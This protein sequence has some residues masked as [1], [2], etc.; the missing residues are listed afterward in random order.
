MRLNVYLLLYM[1]SAASSV[2]RVIAQSGYNMGHKRQL[3]LPRPRRP[4]YIKDDSHHRDDEHCDVHYLCKQLWA[5]EWA[6]HNL[7]YLMMTKSAMILC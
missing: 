1:N 5:N 6:Y 3:T 2:C 7:T 4:W